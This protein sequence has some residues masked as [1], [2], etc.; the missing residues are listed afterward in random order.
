MGPPRVV[1]KTEAI[2]NAKQLVQKAL[3]ENPELRLVLEIAE[4]ARQVESKEPPISIGVGTDVA[5]IPTRP[6]CLVPPAT[7]D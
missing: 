3:R 6:Q 5:A 7:F 1:P 2:M 4:R